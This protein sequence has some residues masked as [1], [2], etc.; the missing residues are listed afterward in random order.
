ML[1]KT[2]AIVLHHIKYGETSLIVTFYTEQFGRITCM[3]NGARAKKSKTPVTLF[4]PLGLLEIDM[5]HKPGK[6]IQ[7]LKDA[8]C[9]QHYTS[10]P[11]SITKSTIALFLAEVLFLSLKEE[12]GNPKLFTFLFHAFQL[13]DNMETGVANFHLWFLLHLTRYLG[14][15]VLDHATGNENLNQTDNQLFA[16][17][18]MQVREA[19]KIFLNN[20]QGPPESV[21]LT[22]VDRTELLE[23]IIR[24]YAI[25]IDGFS[26]IKSYAVLKEIF[27]S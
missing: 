15:S 17:V 8:C 14:V 24:Y 21:L 6:E 13:L 16:N 3:V 19:L 27:K 20:P 1:H 18:S 11:V 5:Y 7:R 2:R 22:H 25:H 12:D 10:L 4:Q 23:A 26:R 9:P